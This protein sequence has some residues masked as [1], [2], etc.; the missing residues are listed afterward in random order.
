MGE[1]SRERRLWTHHQAVPQRARVHSQRQLRHLQRLREDLGGGPSGTHRDP[2]R[3]RSASRAAGLWKPARHCFEG[4]LRPTVCF[5]IHEGKLLLTSY[6]FNVHPLFLCQV[7]EILGKKFPPKENSKGFKVL[8][9]YIRVIQ[10]DGVDINTL[11]EVR[12]LKMLVVVVPQPLFWP[13]TGLKSINFTD[14]SIG[15]CYL[16]FLHFL[17]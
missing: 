11:Q 3:W 14:R 15:D 5:D 1:G 13:Q 12:L 2:Q 4:A 16:V 17:G 6:T 9:P 10:G 8:P 7:L